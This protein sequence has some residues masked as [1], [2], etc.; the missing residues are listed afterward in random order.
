MT[1]MA[2]Q[3]DTSSQSQPES[4]IDVA[5]ARQANVAQNL[6]LPAEATSEQ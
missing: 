6:G 1:E 4:Y 2:P 5:A 3:L